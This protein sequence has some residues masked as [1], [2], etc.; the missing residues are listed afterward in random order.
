M[1]RFDSATQSA[2]ARKRWG[3][4]ESRFWSK[5]QKSEG[6][7]LWQGATGSTSPYG[8]IRAFGRQTTAHRVSYRL[9]NGPIPAGQQVLHTCD[10]PL[11]VKPSHLFLGTQLDNMRDMIS[12]GRQATGHK[13]NHSDQTGELNANAKLT[14]DQVAEMRRLFAAGVSQA[15]LMRSFGTTRANVNCIVRY[16][17]RRKELVV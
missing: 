9:A 12:K 10:N 13:L 7:W 17:S 11:C 15:D 14:N 8:V 1:L 5:V 4:L 6:C 3:T 2:R 16:K